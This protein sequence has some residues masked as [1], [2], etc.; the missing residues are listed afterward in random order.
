ME[1]IGDMEFYTFEEVED[2]IIGKKG[3]PRRDAYEAKIKEELDAYR[4]G[5]AI[6]KARLE[7]H[8]TQK[9]LGELLGVKRAQVSRIEN[10]RNLTFA[11][12]A[13]VFKAL[14]VPASLELAGIGKINLW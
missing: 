7:R 10:G 11:T 9:E 1:K 12:I 14:G 5:E 8:M 3:T 13:R 4:M 6:K 2:E